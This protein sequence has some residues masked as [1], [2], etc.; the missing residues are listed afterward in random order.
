MNIKVQGGQ[1]LSGE[2]YPSGSKNSAVAL[3]PASILIAGEVVLE[4][5]PEITDVKRLVEIMEKLGSKVTWNKEDRKLH[6]DNSNLSLQRLNRNDLGNMKGTSLLWGPLLARFKKVIFDDLPG[7]CTLGARPLDPQYDAF[8]GLKVAIAETKSGVNMDSYKAKAGEVWL[9]EMSPT[10]TE[11]M[12]M[13]AVYLKGKT[14][15]VGAASEPQVQ[16]TC[17][18]LVAAGAKITGIGSNILEIDGG[19]TL[20]PVAYR[21]FSDHYEVGTFIALFAAT[22]GSG[23]IHNTN[24]ELMPIIEHEFSKFGIKINYEGTTAI[25]KKDQKITVS[26]PTKT[27]IVRAQ[28]WPALPVDM[29]PL[30]IPLALRLRTGQVL[31]HNWMYE[32]GLFWTSELQKFGANVVMCD[33][34]R[35]IVSGGN[36]LIGT[37]LEAPYIIRAVVSLVM[38][39]MLAE[40][41]ST[42]LNADALYRGHPHFAENLRRLGALIEETV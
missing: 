31:F 5:V 4:N 19:H 7:G 16:D 8:A 30:Y 28:P 38:V 22:G 24:P 33:P 2:V 29:L 27:M 37:T 15:I 14:K 34:H 9:T 13:L 25:I 12:V 40:G 23:K 35:V 20:K 3:I 17:K 1:T 39:A 42:I 18:F 26:D 6:L 36:K 21:M 41:E 10:V 32:S 11:N